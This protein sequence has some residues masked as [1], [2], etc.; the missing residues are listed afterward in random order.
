M[1]ATVGIMQ[2]RLSAPSPDGPQS[3]PHASWRE[4]FRRAAAL[5]FDCI[6][7]LFELRQHE[8]NPLWTDSG[9]DEIRAAMESS[10][11]AVDSVCAHYFIQWAPFAGAGGGDP[12]LDRLLPALVE[13]AADLGV[14][15]IVVPL[16][17]GASLRDAADHGDLRRL[18]GNALEVAAERDMALAFE[19]DLEAAP[20]RNLLEA[21]ASP[22]ARLCFDAGNATAFGFDIA[23][24]ARCLISWI[25][26]VHIKDRF[27]D[28][29]STALGEGDTRFGPFA[30]ALAAGGYDGGFVL[31]TPAGDAFCDA[32]RRHLAFTRTLLDGAG[33]T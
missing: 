12:A 23:E 25:A 20:C 13:R 28:G 26:E 19:T 2:G 32:A 4:E 33:L 27:V 10:G 21:L 1:S 5:G 14:R 6:E 30:A 7:W 11:V 3:F 31:E 18:V 16:L 15:R 8:R 9:R 24:D 17:E 29:A 22:A